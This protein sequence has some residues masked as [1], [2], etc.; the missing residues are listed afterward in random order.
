M[1]RRFSSWRC[2]AVLPLSVAFC[3][4]ALASRYDSIAILDDGAATT[5]ESRYADIFVEQVAR[6]GAIPATRVENLADNTSGT[7][8]I[9]PGAIGGHAQIRALLEFRR[10]SLPT[11][12]DP[13][14][15]GFLLLTLPDQPNIVIAAGVDERGVL[16]ALGELL[17][18]MT[19]QE[20]EVEI[21]GVI[22]VWTA[23]AFELRGTM[24]S[25]GHT[26]TEL[27][28]ARKWTDAEWRQAALEYALAGA[29]TVALG[30]SVTPDDPQ[31][32]FV[33]S[34]NLKVML[35]LYPNAGSGP[36]E[37]AATEAIGR[38]GF[39]CLSVPEA[40]QHT[41]D[42]ADQ[43]W[44]TMPPVDYLRMYS[45]DGGGCECDKCAPFGAKYIRLCD[46]IANIVHKYQPA[47]E[48]FATNQKLDNAGDQAI[49]D[50]LK[51][52]RGWLR[53]F[54]YGPGSNAMGW[55]PGRRQ[56]HRM[57]LFRYMAFGSI[58]RYLREIVHQL[59][60]DVDLSFYTDVTHW[61]YSQ[62]GLMD[63][64]LIPD[65][66]GDLPPRTDRTLYER[67]PDPALA[68]V[69]DRRTFHA[70]PRN[71]YDV[72]QHTMRYG[73]GDVTY[74][75]GHH[76]HFNQWMWQRLLWAPRTAMEDVVA[77]YARAHFGPDAAGA[78]AQAILQL[79]ENLSTPI[80]TNEGIDVLIN[81]LREARKRIPDHLFR[82]DYLWRQYMQK[83]LLDKYIQLAVRRQRALLR[84]VEDLLRDALDAGAP[85][86]SLDR[87]LHLLG[88]PYETAEMAA[89]KTEADR[90]GR[91]S[92][93]S[94]GVRSEGFFN[95]DQDFIG[96]GWLRREIAAV[97][98]T[99]PEGL[100]EGIRRIVYYEDPGPGGFYDDAGDPARSPHLVHGWPY[101]DGAFSPSDRPSQ[102]SAAFTTTEAQGV[103]FEYDGLDPAAAYRVRF[104]LVRPRYL[105]R[106][107]KFQHQKSESIYA[108]EIALV[109][110]LELPEYESR[111]FEFDVPPDVTR[112]GRLLIRFQKSAG[113]G[114]GPRPEVTVWRNTGGWGTLVSEVWLLRRPQ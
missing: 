88:V 46:E 92:D 56:D 75:E 73:I 66:N 37:W 24:I 102:R 17:R 74:S 47:V 84:S 15:E 97:R 20:G 76:D 1:T 108:D 8:Y 60:P 59:P 45:G 12:K 38:P 65:R 41:L 9:C 2:C 113:V 85:A 14:P 86:D 18:R 33:K 106:F 79:E 23:P 53:S 90:L 69:Y 13:G 83:A 52:H 30:Y 54:S 114:E 43:A 107:G 89:L 104:T 58:D 82:R 34:L 67:K 99:P 36:P 19:F 72:F 78:M 98:S 48:I 80:E 49:F 112:D 31:Y 11:E 93:A 35:S 39:L 110:D 105:P 111:F 103:T 16:Y 25:Q 62:Y 64:E 7:L 29:N 5:I 70:R 100:R 42:R 95:L 96:L 40:W 109:E 55:M 77:E 28:G 3:V 6:R 10:I 94:F 44:R 32:Q 61:V 101:G 50:Y 21:T 26:I 22:N 81:A 51:A 68:Q 4:V 27:T 57:D 87:A 91:E 63:H 71:Y